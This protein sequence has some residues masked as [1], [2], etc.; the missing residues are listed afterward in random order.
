MIAPRTQQRSVPVPPPV[1]P[2]TQE[3][4]NVLDQILE[5]M[6]NYPNDCLYTVEGEPSL[7]GIPTTLHMLKEDIQHF[8]QR[9]DIGVYPIMFYIRY[10]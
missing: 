1:A 4:R 10:A 5:I 2:L 3:N 9:E 8:M 7:F 6:V